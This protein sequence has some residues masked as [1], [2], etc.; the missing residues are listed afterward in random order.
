MIRIAFAAGAAALVAVLALNARPATAA[1]STSAKEACVKVFERQRAC[2]TDFIPAL[3]DL[4]A[5]VDKPK[6]IAAEAA[7]PGGRDALIQQALS[8]W[9]ND[10]TDA[11]IDATCS[12]IASSPK[13]AGAKTMADSCVSSPD[14]PG[15]VKCVIPLM[16]QTL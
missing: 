11:A 7:K 15:F 12:R 2:T 6:G 5:S 13:A 16:K 1:A 14:C 3:V 4:R 8:E 9:K 10:S